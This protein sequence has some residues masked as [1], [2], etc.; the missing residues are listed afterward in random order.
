M[1]NALSLYLR[2][3]PALSVLTMLAQHQVRHPRP[4]ILTT[5]PLVI[6]TTR[7]RSAP[8]MSR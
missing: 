3:S 4:L 1:S 5:L 8:V 2:N 7:P 6:M